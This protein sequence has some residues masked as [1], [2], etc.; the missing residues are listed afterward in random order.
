MGHDQRVPQ[1]YTRQLETIRTRV[2]EQSNWRQGQGKHV[3]HGLEF[4]RVPE[5]RKCADVHKNV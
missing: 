4:R 1:E 5:S 2:I 3:E